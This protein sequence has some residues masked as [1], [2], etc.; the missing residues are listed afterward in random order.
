MWRAPNSRVVR[1]TRASTPS[2]VGSPPRGER[3][4][5]CA[6]GV[7]NGESCSHLSVTGASLAALLRG[8][9]LQSGRKGLATTGGGHA[10]I[11]GPYTPGATYAA[12]STGW[13]S[14]GRVRSRQQLAVAEVWGGGGGWRPSLACFSATG[15]LTDRAK[16][17]AAHACVRACVRSRWPPS[18]VTLVARA[19]ARRPRSRGRPPYDA[20]SS[21]RACGAR[22]HAQQQMG[23]QPGG[24]PPP[25]SDEA[26]TSAVCRPRAASRRHGCGAPA[27]GARLDPRD[28][29]QPSSQPL[30]H[31]AALTAR[32]GRR[33]WPRLG[34]GVA[35]GQA[36]TDELST[37]HAGW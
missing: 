16:L 18:I 21:G 5:A 36:T 23:H 6:V 4:Y 26:P 13:R 7:A 32:C 12:P 30:M 1:A 34:R 19:L 10:H 27:A 11:D 24:A 3:R 28:S 9:L 8:C 37:P 31:R 35:P 15:R 22:T 14:C 2:R 33:V 29:S 20:T 25:P 17:A